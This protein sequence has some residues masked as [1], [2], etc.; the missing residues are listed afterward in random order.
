MMMPVLY[1]ILILEFYFFV[2][3]Q[4]ISINQA[5]TARQYVASLSF[6]PSFF[7]L[8]KNPVCVIALEWCSQALIGTSITRALV[9][10]QILIQ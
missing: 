5:Q 10:M 9:K 3:I 8:S 7:F 1:L 2:L 6:F 4:H